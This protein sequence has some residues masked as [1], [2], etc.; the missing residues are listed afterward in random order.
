MAL[1]LTV[2]IVVGAVAFVILI[3]AIVFVVW[4]RRNPPYTQVVRMEDGTGIHFLY[5]CTF[6]RKCRA[7]YKSLSP[8]I[9]NTLFLNKILNSFEV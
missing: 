6:H 7:E 5:L 3:A 9:T 8:K 1:V 4:R 2:G